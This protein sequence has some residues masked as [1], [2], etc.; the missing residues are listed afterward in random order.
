MLVHLYDRGMR[1]PPPLSCL[2]SAAHAAAARA[3]TDPVAAGRGA[4]ESAYT[5]DR[6]DRE[7]DH[8]LVLGG[9]Q[10]FDARLSE[11]ARPDE[12]GPWWDPD[13]PRRFGRWARRLWEGL[14][15]VEE[16]TD[17]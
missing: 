15:Q 16:I 7:P 14:L 17:R 12:R 3:G 2:A 5:F 1:E 8:Q 13:E 4:W 10:P 11:R 6:E 9:V